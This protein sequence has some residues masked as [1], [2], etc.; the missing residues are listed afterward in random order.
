VVEDFVLFA[1]RH[2]SDYARQEGR[3]VVFYGERD[4]D[5]MTC[6]LDVF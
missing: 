3:V 2:A 5:E 4:S 1:E 6:A